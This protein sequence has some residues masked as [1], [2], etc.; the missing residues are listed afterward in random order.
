[1]TN[2]VKKLFGG[3]AGA[4]TGPRES[5]AAGEIYAFRTAPLSDFAAPET[6]RFAALKILGVSEE[7]VVLAV[8]DGIWGTRPAPQE[9]GRCAILTQHRFSYRGQA[10]VAGVY[11]GAWDV[12]LLRDV[13]RVADVP[14]TRKERHLGDYSRDH[15]GYYSNILFANREAEGEWRWKH[16]RE[17]LIAETAL[18]E[19]RG[20]AEEAAREARYRDRIQ[21]LTWDQLLA[22]AHFAN[23]SPS[24]PYPPPDFTEGAR[25]AI[26]AACRDLRDLG[27]KP[28]RGDVRAI[29]RRTVIWFNEADERAGG[30]IETGEREDIF[31]LLEEMAHVARQ[32]ALVEE[33]DVWRDW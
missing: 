29:L 21:G 14:L 6:G 20:A 10:A 33:I 22:E 13:T 3:R 9:V 24:P 2:W 5:P 28:R 18:A 26:L 7:L 11:R 1:M 17:A 31:A 32:K 27:P 8:L 30:V 19:A 16:D 25:A 12:S 23:W 15:R 4:A